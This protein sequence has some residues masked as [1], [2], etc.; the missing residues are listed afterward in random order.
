MQNMHMNP[1][2]SGGGGLS[3]YLS[4]IT[5]ASDGGLSPALRGNP[6]VSTLVSQH[7]IAP[8]LTAGVSPLAQDGVC[9]LIECIMWEVVKLGLPQLLMVHNGVQI[10]HGGGKVV[11]IIKPHFKLVNVPQC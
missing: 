3:L 10:P 4:E 11:F 2:V 1:A 9:Y 7:G 5:S 8:G 6:L